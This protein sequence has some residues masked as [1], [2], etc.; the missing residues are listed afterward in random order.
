MKKLLFIFCLLIGLPV[1]AY[2]EKTF[3][4]DVSIDGKVLTTPEYIIIVKD[5]DTFDTQMWLPPDDIIIV[6]DEYVINP[7]EQEKAEIEQIMY[8]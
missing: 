4:S 8:R 3:L 7:N 5:Y 6:D 2:T 1:M